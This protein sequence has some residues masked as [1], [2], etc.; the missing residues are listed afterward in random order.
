MPLRHGNCAQT[1]GLPMVFFGVR[2]PI[3]G[4]RRITWCCSAT[5]GVAMGRRPALLRLLD[6]W[7]AA[8]AMSTDRPDAHSGAAECRGAQCAGTG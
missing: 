8:S 2:K 6:L 4:A 7:Y 1:R 5:E 3:R